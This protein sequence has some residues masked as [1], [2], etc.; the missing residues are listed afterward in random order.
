MDRLSLSAR[1]L[2]ALPAALALT[3]LAACAS[4]TR[5]RP[6]SDMPVRIGPPY[7][8][9]GTTYTPAADPTYDFLGYATWYGN[10]SGNQTA[11][12]ERFRADWVTAA[13]RT[14]PLPSYVEVTALATGR[15]I[16]VRVNDRGPFTEK[17]RII[18]LSKGAAELL[19]V[20]AQGKSGVRVRVVSP[21]EADRA[22]L[23]QGKPA[24][25]LP[26]ISPRALAS[27]RA[28]FEAG[29]GSL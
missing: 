25:M 3:A 12:G 22:A 27:L 10:E 6:V 24:R 2:R 1:V 28:Q 18:D 7:T 11:N 23:R 8:V 21:D 13:H 9:R 5:Y 15:R 29:V 16:L 20:R 26:P 19:G 4:G 14:L 17:A